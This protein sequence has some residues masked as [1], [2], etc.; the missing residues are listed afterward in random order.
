[1]L[2][3]AYAWSVKGKKGSAM[4]SV[5]TALELTGVID[6]NH[7]LHLDRGVPISGP[8]RVRVIILYSPDD[9]WSETQWLKAAARNP[10]FD[11][12]KDPAEDIYT[13]ADG[14]PFYDQV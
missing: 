4:D 13:L 9:E 14:I 10:V 5:M 12:L 1:M 8:T 11:F 7:H 2:Q 3:Y 6:E